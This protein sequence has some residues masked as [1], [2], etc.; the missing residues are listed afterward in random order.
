V[1]LLVHPA[2]LDASSVEALDFG[3]EADAA[4]AIGFVANMNDTGSAASLLG[5]VPGDLGGHAQSGFDRSTYLQGSG[6]SEK[7]TAAGDVQGF[8]KV[9]GLVGCD[10]YGPE[11]QRSAGAEAGDLPA[12]WG[13]FHV[14]RLPSRF[15]GLRSWTGSLQRSKVQELVKY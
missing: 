3:T 6:R 9:F 11:A 10:A 7:E 4:I 14:G 15:A 5:G 8:G 12:F 13:G 2:L 1:L